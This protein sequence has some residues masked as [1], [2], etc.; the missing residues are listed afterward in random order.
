MG[1]IYAFEW[2]TNVGIA[3]KSDRRKNPCFAV[4]GEKIGWY[5]ICIKEEFRMTKK[6]M[7]IGKA[8][9][10]AEIVTP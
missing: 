3:K 7:F 5:F 1:D 9:E 4:S 6:N 10:R 2:C 8:A